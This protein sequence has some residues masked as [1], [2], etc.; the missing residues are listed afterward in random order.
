MIDVVVVLVE[1]TKNIYYLSPNSLTLKKGEEVIFENENGLLNGIVIKE[2]YSEKKANLVLPLKK[3]LRVACETDKKTISKNRNLALKALED[4]KKYSNTLELNMNF[5][6]SYL[7]FDGSQILLSFMSEDRVDFRD[8]VK[9]LAQKYKIRIE[10][11]QIGVRDKAKK[12]GGLGP[13]GLFLCCNSFLTD[14]NSVSINM[15]KNQMLALNPT[16]ING[17]CGRLLCCLG[18]E[19][20]N[21]TELKK[22]L[23]KLGLVMDTPEGMG[24]VVDLDVFGNT[25]SVDLGDK[26]IMKFP[27]EKRNGKNG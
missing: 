11:R 5:V 25:Y 22:S 26:G 10:L 17:I 13:C 15:A 23:P 12:V 7:N 27:G 3:V 20:D 14:F 9:K 16:K 4:A 2:T 6:D 21:Y 19:N 1:D 8:L 18:Y 24:K